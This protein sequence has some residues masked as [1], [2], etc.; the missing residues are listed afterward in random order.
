MI[1]FRFYLAPG[2]GP[3]A[4]PPAA[5]LQP[6]KLIAA[7][8]DGVAAMTRVAAAAMVWADSFHDGG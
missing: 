3:P 1:A 5:A 7:A 8:P 6:A 4:E 2:Q